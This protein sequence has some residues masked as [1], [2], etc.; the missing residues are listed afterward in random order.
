MHLFKNIRFSVIILLLICMIPVYSHAAEAANKTTL[1]RVYQNDQAL[2]EY[3]N[4]DK[5]KYYASTLKHS[6][7][8]EIT[9]RKWLADNLPRYRVYQNDA[10]LPDGEFTSLPQA[11]AFAA[12]YNHASIKD[13]QAPGWV[14]DNYPKYRLF[15]GEIT[16]D[17]WEFASIDDAKKEA[18][19][20]LNAHIILL[21]DNSWVWDNLTKQQ[22]KAQRAQT[23]RY[24]IYQSETT[25]EEWKF[26]YLED[27]IRIAAK[28]DNST[29]VLFK[30][31]IGGATNKIVYSNL[32]IYS[33][34]QKENLVDSFV[35][36]KNAIQFA[37]NYKHVSVRVG[38]TT[39][40]TNEASFKVMNGDE[41]AGEFNIIA[42][43]VAYALTVN[44]SL[45]IN[46]INE[47]IWSNK[48][49]LIYWGWNGSS[50]LTAIQNQLSTTIGLD[51]DSPSWFKLADASGK[52]DDASSQEAAD[53]LFSQGFN[54]HPLVN[55]QF[56]AGM[57]T[58][59]LADPNAQALFIQSLIDRCVELKLTGINV[60]FESLAGNDRDKFT[61]F[62]Q[63]LTTYAHQKGLTVSLDLPRGSLKWNQLTAFDHIQLGG[64]VDYIMIMTYDQFYS[65]SATAGPVAGLNWVEEGIEE[66]LSYGIPREKIIMGIPFYVREW[67]LNKNGSLAS[68]KAIYVEDIPDL[69]KGKSV[70][71]TWDAA[72]GQNKIEYVEGGKTHVFWNENETTLLAR[73]TLA[74]KLKIA[75]IAAWRL[76]YEPNSF[77]QTLMNE[78]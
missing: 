45:I 30:P 46:D 17:T 19:S 73:V 68:N 2:E 15:Q 36:L 1:Y 29:I 20:Y 23:K 55:N 28:L 58:K 24:Q 25:K 21:E 35:S 38:E 72:A 52:L 26:S 47:V 22:K 76:G 31:V 32:K 78:K 63:N 69:L 48:S 41:L 51:I 57:T 53:W 74:K 6:H 66:F 5:A 39:I 9:S 62:I 65:G 14:W 13:L 42:E 67:T 43:A 3:D 10:P 27:A 61:A 11:K 49:K 64:I 50:S 75:G 18:K 4:L 34:Y 8:E 60:D 77:W 70:K 71:T 7:V 44:D 16:K 40:W 12:S 54:V 59:F 37:M 56:N 33:V